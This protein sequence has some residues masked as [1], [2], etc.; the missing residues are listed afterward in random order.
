MQLELIN[1]INS[2]EIQVLYYFQAFNNKG[3]IL[4]FKF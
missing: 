2:F 4:K 1:I 3:W